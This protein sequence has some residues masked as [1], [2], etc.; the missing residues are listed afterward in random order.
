MSN[1]LFLKPAP[2]LYNFRCAQ[3]F[4]GQ[5]GWPWVCDNLESQRYENLVYVRDQGPGQGDVSGVGLPTCP[6]H[7]VEGQVRAIHVPASGYW[8]FG[9]EDLGPSPHFS[10]VDKGHTKRRQTWL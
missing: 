8:P 4:I 1:P 9:A 6:R 7:S 5:A 10:L 3:E 2:V